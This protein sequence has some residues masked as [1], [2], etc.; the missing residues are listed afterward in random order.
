MPHAAMKNI[1]L[2]EMY[3]MRPSPTVDIVV[4]TNPKR[5]AF[6]DPKM[7]LRVELNGAIKI[8]AM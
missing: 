4:S 1:L 2:S 7:F 8:Y 5:M 3:D 6:L